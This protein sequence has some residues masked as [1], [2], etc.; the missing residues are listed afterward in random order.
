MLKKGGILLSLLLCTTL[1]LAQD[2]T[3]D[4]FR[5]DNPNLMNL[6]EA[7]E[8][9][10]EPLVYIEGVQAPEV[11]HNDMEALQL[12]LFGTKNVQEVTKDSLELSKESMPAPTNQIQN[13]SFQNPFRQKEQ[14]AFI[15]H[16]PNFATIIHVQERNKLVVN[17]Y[18]TVMNTDKDLIW[19]RKIPLPSTATATITDYIQN[20]KHFA[21]NMAPKTDLLTF[22]SPQPLELGPNQITLTYQIENPLTNNQ[23]DLDITGTDLAWPIAQFQTLV[24]LPAPKTLQASKL[25]FGT[26]QLE[27]PDIYTQRT[28][29]NA[30]IYFQINRIV[31]PNASIQARLQ[32]DLNQLPNGRTTSSS[33]LIMGGGLILL[34]LYWLSFAWW[35]KHFTKQ[36]PL[37]KMRRPKNPNLFAVQTG[38][39][40]TDDSWRK[41]CAFEA[42]NQKEAATLLKRYAGWQKHPVAEKTK[43]TIQNFFLLT[44]EVIIGTTL[45]LIGMMIALYYLDQSA[46]NWILWAYLGLSFGALLLLYFLALKSAQKTMWQKRLAQ[47]SSEV[48]LAGLTTQQIRQIYPLFILSQQQDEWRQKLVRTNPK[49]VQNAHLL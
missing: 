36:I 20:G 28:D 9:T 11:A 40:L 10:G 41:L 18:I 2:K 16:I 29:N 33:T 45:L 30:N 4:L 22:E 26:N 31:P 1:A 5:H 42:Q 15:H 46:A 48:V 6:G 25:T 23:L 34:I 39:P 13:Y 19:T 17:E 3:A 12:K 35:N 38:F 44:L 27:I 14:A 32:L 49:A 43:A 37:S 24:L 7:K 47:L 21:V 8:Y